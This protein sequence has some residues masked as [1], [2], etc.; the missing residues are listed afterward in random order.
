MKIPKLFVKETEVSL[1]KLLEEK[2]TNKM[3]KKEKPRIGQ[4][5]YIP[6]S[7]YLGH[8]RDDFIGGLCTIVN[9]KEGMSA[10]E[11]M[12]FVE[13]AERPGQGY[14]WEYLQENQGKWKKEY[15]KKRG[16]PDPDYRAEFN[17]W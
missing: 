2:P 13:V 11:Y 7:L 4:E 9:V 14:N 12:P 10:G 8:G 3:H 15:G 6:T 5:I 17:D 16:K 1:E